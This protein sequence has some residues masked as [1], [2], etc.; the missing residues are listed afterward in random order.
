MERSVPKPSVLTHAEARELAFILSAAARRQ[1]CLA[2]GVLE[3]EN[4]RLLAEVARLVTYAYTGHH[5]RTHAPALKS[6]N[7]FLDPPNKATSPDRIAARYRN[8]LWKNMQR[9]ETS[10]E[11]L[12]TL[13]NCTE[14]SSSSES[15]KDT[16]DTADRPSCSAASETSECILN[17][18]R[19]ELVDVRQYSTGESDHGSTDQEME[20][21]S[22]VIRDLD[23]HGWQLQTCSQGHP[24]G[25]RRNR[26]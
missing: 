4:R 17:N 5:K 3:R 13:L 18:V 12:I 20:L 6:C 25:S 23:D 16:S 22:E 10:A 21:L 2:Y 11:R 9:R 7:P 19:S 24:M 26:P 8:T 14:P 15:G 1:W